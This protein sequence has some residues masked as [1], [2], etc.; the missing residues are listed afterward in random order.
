M[1]QRRPLSGNT[2]VP[3]IEEEV[4]IGWPLLWSE[5][6]SSAHFV[7]FFLFMLQLPEVQVL[8]GGVGDCVSV[9]WI[10]I[11]KYLRTT[12]LENLQLHQQ[13]LEK[14][15]PSV[16][17]LDRR[18]TCSMACHIVGLPLVREAASVPMQQHPQGPL[19]DMALGAHLPR[20]LRSRLQEQR[21]QL[22]H[23][24]LGYQADRS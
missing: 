18:L 4:E 7:V 20:D 6:L 14:L 12:T 3:P 19:L 11:F 16:Q 8:L 2:A 15:G 1:C 9:T 13:P 22:Q 10:Q 21:P 17:A 5:S 24:A 23:K